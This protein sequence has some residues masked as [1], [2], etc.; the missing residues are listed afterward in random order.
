VDSPRDT[1]GAGGTYAFSG[2]PT[3][4]AGFADFG[5]SSG[6]SEATPAPTGGYQGFGSASEAL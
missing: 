5:A 2:E 1:T 3:A 6:G 4:K